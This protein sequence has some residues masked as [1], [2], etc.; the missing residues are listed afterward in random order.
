[1]LA[2][3]TGLYPVIYKMSAVRGAAAPADVPAA[4]DGAF[5]DRDL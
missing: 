3:V 4:D 2:Q 5:G 1:M